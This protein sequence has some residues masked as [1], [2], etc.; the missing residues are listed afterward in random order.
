M[1]S[2]DDEEDKKFLISFMPVRK[3]LP[4]DKNMCAR[5]NITEVTQQAVLLSSVNTGQPNIPSAF[6]TFSNQ[7]HHQNMQYCIPN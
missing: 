6:F 1:P 7:F 4:M 5:L 2:D 3:K